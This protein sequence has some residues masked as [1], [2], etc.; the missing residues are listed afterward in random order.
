MPPS[1]P[2]KVAARRVQRGL[3]L[4][5]MLVAIAILGLTLGALYNAVSGATRNTRSGEKY[6]YG[7]ELARSLLADNAVVPSGGVS[8]EGRTAGEFQ[9]RV[10]SEP[11]A[12]AGD[13]VLPRLQTIEVVVSWRDGERVRRV[14][15]QSVVE[16]SRP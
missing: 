4:L 2:I 7:V 12:P 1:R 13:G 3:S 14:A 6:L 15:L 9:W 16:G 10:R 11:V 5:E 8:M